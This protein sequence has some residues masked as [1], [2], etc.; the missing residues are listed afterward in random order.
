MDNKLIIKRLRDEQ[1]TTRAEKK[2]CLKSK[3]YGDAAEWNGYIAGLE[4]AIS[5]IKDNE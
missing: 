3:T 4:A 1:K 2:N 5:I